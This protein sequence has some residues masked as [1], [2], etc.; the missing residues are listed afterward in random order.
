M[1]VPHDSLTYYAR[2]LRAE[3]LLSPIEPPPTV[4]SI[5]GTDPTGGAGMHADLKT[6]SALGGFAMGAVTA[7]V[8]QNT[9]GVRTF[10]AME[11]EL[12]AEQIDSVFEDV[13]VDAV[14][15]GMLANAKIIGTVADRLRA[16]DARNVVVDPVMVSTSGDLLLDPRAI[17]A[18][19]TRLLPLA[20]IITPNIPEAAALLDGQAATTVEQMYTAAEQLLRTGSA[21][22]LLKGGHLQELEQ[23]PDVLVGPERHEFTAPRV[24]TSNDHGTGCTLS[25]AI[26]ALLPH[27]SV[28]E[29]VRI[30]KTYLSGALRFADVLDVGHGHGPVNH[31]AWLWEAAH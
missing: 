25:A 1:Y 31:F 11:S 26:A 18:M 14:K 16:H 15:I 12:V 13:R 10:A 27:H 6:V 19:R 24:L 20:T 22:V 17:E 4:L 21:W 23:S 30:A 8:A 3:S 29:A 2:Q 9:R 28:P 7:V 5:A